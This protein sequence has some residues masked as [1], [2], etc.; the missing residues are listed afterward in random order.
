VV[1]VV[2]NLWQRPVGGYRTRLANFRR[3][4]LWRRYDGVLASAAKS[5]EAIRAYGMPESV[6]ISIAW[7]PS[8]P[9]PHTTDNGNASFLPQKRE[10]EFFVGFAGRITAAKGWRVLLAAMTELPENFKCLVAG[11]GEEEAELRL[12]C[13]VPA[14]CSRVRYFG[15]LEK[16]RLWSFYRALDA[17][18][19]PSL[20][21][22]HWTEQFGLVLAEAMACGV[23][24]L[25]S[26]S[27]AIP[28]VIGDCGLVV[29][30]NN[31]AALAQAIQTLAADPELRG[32]CKE[33]GLRRFERE[34]TARAYAARIAKVLGMNWGSQLR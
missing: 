7:L 20:T 4:Q 5:A 2:E 24:V 18:V 27:G 23:P 11:A 22:S 25:G 21:T 30:E 6:P 15:V 10:G 31:P 9:P 33:A 28:E 32:R 19:L 14:I 3:E 17:F 12:W 29:E 8:L 34:F 26:T 1:H 13:Q 16:E